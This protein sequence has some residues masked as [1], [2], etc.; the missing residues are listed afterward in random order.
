MRRM[1]RSLF[2][3]V[4]VYGCG[5]PSLDGYRPSGLDKPL[6]AFYQTV[7]KAALQGRQMLTSFNAARA[8]YFR[9]YVGQAERQ[10]RVHDQSPPPP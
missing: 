3:A 5:H 1:W 4:V 2:I 8:S 7:N 6:Q 10:L 9:A